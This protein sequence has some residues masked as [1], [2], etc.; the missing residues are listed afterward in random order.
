MARAPKRVSIVQFL[1]HVGVRPRNTR[2]T[3]PSGPVSSSSKC[4]RTVRRREVKSR[5][6][7][8]E[9][10]RERVAEFER[11]SGFN[12]EDWK[13]H[14]E[15]FGKAVQ[16]VLNCEIFRAYGSVETLHRSLVDVVEVIGK[17]I[18]CRDNGTDYVRKKPQ[19]RRRKHD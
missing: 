6:N 5:T 18:E 15:E 2:A 4:H 13:L 12:L 19:I 17:V 1:P 7:Q 8:Y 10:L 9:S 11:A 3:R 14:P 16:F